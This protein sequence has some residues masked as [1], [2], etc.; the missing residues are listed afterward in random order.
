MTDDQGRPRPP[1]S[2]DAVG[3]GVLI[4]ATVGGYLL[5]FNLGSTVAL[6]LGAVALLGAV[7][8]LLQPRKELRAAGAAVLG[9]IAV[10]LLLVGV[11]FK[12]VEGI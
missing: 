6:V 1:S 8:L 12:A 11:C 4:L 3:C 9:G 5:A 2:A 7:V 10:A